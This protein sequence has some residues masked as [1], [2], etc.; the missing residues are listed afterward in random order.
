MARFLK[1]NAIGAE[2]EKLIQEATLDIFL[3]SPYIKLHNR[4]KSELRDLKKDP[5]LI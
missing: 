3:I 1:G 5:R 4:I 2:I